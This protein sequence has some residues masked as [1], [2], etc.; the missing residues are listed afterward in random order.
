[1]DSLERRLNPS[2]AVP[3]AAEIHAP[4]VHAAPAVHTSALFHDVEASTGT[5][6]QTAST[7]GRHLLTP[8]NSGGTIPD[9]NGDP[10][11]GTPTNP[12]GPDQPG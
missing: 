8:D 12:D 11:I 9:G 2:P 6:A 1:M 10:P 7:H 5:G 4:A 3:V